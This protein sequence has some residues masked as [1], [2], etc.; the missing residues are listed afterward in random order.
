MFSLTMSMIP[1]AAASSDSPIA[2]A[3]VPTAARAASTSSAISPPARLVGRYPRTTLASVTVGCSPP[4][5]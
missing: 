1:A 5:P 4:L 2:S 3:T